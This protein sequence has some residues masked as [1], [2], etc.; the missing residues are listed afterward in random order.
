MKTLR[1]V[2]DIESEVGQLPKIRVTG[3]E[4]ESGPD[5]VYY[6]RNLLAEIEAQVLA[7]TILK[8]L[9]EAPRVTVPGMVPP[10]DILRRG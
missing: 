4:Q 10:S 9:R 2:I 6:L 5:L 3:A 7:A 8:K 1:L